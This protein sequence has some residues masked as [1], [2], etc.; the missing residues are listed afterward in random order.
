[1]RARVYVYVWVSV[2]EWL[3]GDRFFIFDEM[4]LIGNFAWDLLA[5]KLFFV[6]LF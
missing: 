5:I 3:K 1:V 6:L 4:T 2:G